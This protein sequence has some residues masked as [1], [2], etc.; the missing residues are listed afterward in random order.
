MKNIV[1]IRMKGEEIAA[2]FSFDREEQARHFRELA[3]R[4]IVGEAEII[5]G[6]EEE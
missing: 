4:H 2:Y 6:K 3:M 1:G 5:I